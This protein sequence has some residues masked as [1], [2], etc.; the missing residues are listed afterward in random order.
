MLRAA[1]PLF[2]MPVSEVVV[3]L[4]GLSLVSKMKLFTILKSDV[5]ARTAYVMECRYG[6]IVLRHLLVMYL[7][8][9]HHG[10]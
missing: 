7:I 5:M 4:K 10:S 1:M 8:L 2:M 3:M 6:S 9:F